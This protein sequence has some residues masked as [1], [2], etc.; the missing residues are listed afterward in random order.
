[1]NSG[2][3]TAHSSQLTAKYI[4]LLVVG[5]LAVSGLLRAQTTNAQINVDTRLVPTTMTLVWEADSYTPP[6]YKGKA[7]MPEGG[8]AR[9]VAFLPPGVSATPSTVYTWRVDGTVDAANSGVGRSTYYLRSPS[10]GGSPLVVVEAT[11][12]GSVIGMG[13]IK[14]PLTDPRVLV[15]ED[16][17]LGGIM[18]NS[19][20]VPAAVGEVALEAFP[21]FASAPQRNDIDLSYQWVVGGFTVDN[22]LGNSPRLIMRSEEPRTTPID[23]IVRNASNI[24]ERSSGKTTISFE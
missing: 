1:M 22:P 13:A 14:V 20:A 8:D 11:A 24:L 10:F 17:P 2:K 16:A 21:L 5:C 9:I 12:N 3:L 7:L 23:V 6:F 19:A 15:Y 18:F 4:L